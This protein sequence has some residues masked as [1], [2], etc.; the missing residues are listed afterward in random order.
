MFSESC[1]TFASSQLM[2]AEELPPEPPAL[3]RQPQILPVVGAAWQSWQG[4]QG[5][6]CGAEGCPPALPH[7]CW[8]DS[9][10]LVHALPAPGAET[11]WVACPCLLMGIPPAPWQSMGT[12]VTPK[13][14]CSAHRQHLCSPC[15]PLAAIRSAG[16]HVGRKG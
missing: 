11:V 1:F 14:A 16:R 15:P 5:S 6:R 4:K 7:R 3:P 9:A 13:F 10:S 8:P 12:P 2:E